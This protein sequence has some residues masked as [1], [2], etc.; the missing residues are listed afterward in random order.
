MRIEAPSAVLSSALALLVAMTFS[1]AAC[2][3]DGSSAATTG[4][5]G[6]GIGP[7]TDDEGG[8]TNPD[9]SPINPADG[10]GMDAAIDSS[11]TCTG[12]TG[13]VGDRSVVL[14]VD[15][16]ARTYDLHVPPGYDATKRTPL[17]FLFHGYTM[18]AAQIATATH[19]AATADARGYIAAFPTGIGTSFNA[20]DCCGQ[21]LSDM[22]DDVSF[23]RAMI[24]SVAGD[25]CVDAKRTFASGFSNGGFLSYLLACELSD[26]IAA[27]AS[28]SGGL[29]VDAAA[30][31]PKRPVPL[32]HVHGTNDFV[33]PYDGG[34]AGNAKPVSVSIDAF[35]TI[36]GCA[37]GAGAVVFTKD[38]VSCT[39]WSGCTAGADV[40]LC[41]VTG[42]GHQ[43]PGGDQLPYG[44]ALSANL[45]TS[46]AIADF[47]DAH[48]IP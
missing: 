23:T 39:K 24:T 48:P 8:T 18:T 45:D 6:V 38:D 43:W 40:E 33:V 47:F 5:G 25:Y 9:R 31:K 36:N 4:E 10:G 2:G 41:T 30:C 11:S 16:K 15:G 1:A 42:G 22:V 34:G 21:A 19:F 20:G 17:V 28:V 12:K 27:V 46:K 32:F 35:K 37:A 7:G 29:R 44:P 26:E 14:T 13:A 3:S